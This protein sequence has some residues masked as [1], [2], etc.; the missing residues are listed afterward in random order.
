MLR[1][2]EEAQQHV[3]EDRRGRHGAGGIGDRER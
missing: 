2:P 3:E 1:L